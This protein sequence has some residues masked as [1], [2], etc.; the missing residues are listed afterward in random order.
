ML[1]LLDSVINTAIVLKLI[2]YYVGVVDNVKN[3]VVML[4]LIDNVINT[5]II[6]K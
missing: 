4:R 2:D 1:G 5:A 6:L 3:T